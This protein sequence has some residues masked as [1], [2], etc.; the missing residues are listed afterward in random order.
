MIN[1]L[2]FFSFIILLIP[3]E[4]RAN[5]LVFVFGFTAYQFIYL[6]DSLLIYINS[7]LTD[8]DTSFYY[9]LSTT[10]IYVIIK[11]LSIKNDY[12]SLIAK[13]LVALMVVNMGG[14]F[15]YDTYIDPVYYNVLSN[16]L[17][18]L[19]ICIFTWSLPGGRAFIKNRHTAMVHS[20]NTKS[21]S[22]QI[23]QRKEKGV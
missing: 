11:Q 9:A 1:S 15:M 10:I 14:W 8:Y 17:L 4:T 18:L 21:G 19:I 5:A 23:K 22:M 20:L 13:I 12:I 7:H 6:A 16:T 2:I 3:K